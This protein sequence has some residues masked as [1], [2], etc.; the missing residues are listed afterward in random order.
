[1]TQTVKDVAWM[2]FTVEVTDASRVARVM[3]V[4]AD[5]PGVLKVWR[6]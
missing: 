1:Q 4:L 2:T 5:V 6:R 3:A